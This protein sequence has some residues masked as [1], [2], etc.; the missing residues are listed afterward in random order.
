[1]T[2]RKHGDDQA[3]RISKKISSCLSPENYE[4]VKGR[5]LGGKFSTDSAVVNECIRLV[6]EVT[7]D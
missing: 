4:F 5:G 6:R 1:M 2:K 3:R 7:D